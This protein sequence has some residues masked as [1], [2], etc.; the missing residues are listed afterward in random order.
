[1]SQQNK[2]TGFQFDASNVP[3]AAPIEAFPAG[4]YTA[5]ITDGEI[6]PTADGSGQRMNLEFTVMDGDFKGRKV[7]DGLNI[8]NSSTQAQEIAHQQLSAICHATSVIRFNDIQEL[9]GRPFL[10]KAGLEPKRAVLG[11]Q[12]VPLDTPGAEIYEPRNTFKGAK[13]LTTAGAG[14]PATGSAPATVAGG[15]T[16]PPWAT[17][18]PAGGQAPAATAPG[19][20]AGPGKPGKGKAAPPKPP[21]AER[22]FFV[23]LNDEDDGMPECT[24]SQINIMIAKGMPLSTPL[25]PVDAEGNFSD[26]GWKDAASFGFVEVQ[27]P[28]PAAAASA[29]APVAPPWAR[30]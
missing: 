22:K 23:Y 6:K 30:A 3:P 2:F 14:S 21:Q 16:P 1:M 13:A 11:G 29:G 7:F 18:Q 5:T 9:F 19:K 15:A 27:S 20:P 25:N 12:T 24:D 4:W 28:G 17:K 10:L 26:D 8:V